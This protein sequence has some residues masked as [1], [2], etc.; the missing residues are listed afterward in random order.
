MDATSFE[1]AKENIYEAEI[2]STKKKKKEGERKEARDE[3]VRVF[4][5]SVKTKN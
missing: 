2:I 5:S 3:I 4:D 1:N